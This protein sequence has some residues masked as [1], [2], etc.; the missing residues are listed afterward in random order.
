MLDGL[1]VEKV[2]SIW[3][4]SLNSQPQDHESKSSPQLSS[5]GLLP[6]NYFFLQLIAQQEKL[7]DIDGFV[8]SSIADRCECLFTDENLMDSMLICSDSI[9]STSVAYQS[10]LMGFATDD[11]DSLVNFLSGAV[12][13]N[14]SISVSNE[15]LT[16]RSECDITVMSSDVR[17]TDDDGLSLGIIIGVA[18]GGGVIVIIIL[19]FLVV[20]VVLLVVIIKKKRDK[21]KIDN[22][23]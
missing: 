6:N 15:L 21:N 4:R 2:N 13:D 14:Q 19:V 18:A 22:S 17:C 7:A 1:M 5:V 20:L 16:I 11:C 12:Q 8:E 23:Q 9:S 3:R 10:E